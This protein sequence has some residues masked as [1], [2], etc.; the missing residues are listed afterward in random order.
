[1]DLAKGQTGSILES[2][3]PF[4]PRRDGA[5]W[6]GGE[7]KKSKSQIRAEQI[8]KHGFD[9]IRIFHVYDGQ[10]VTLCK[11]VHR[12]EN[13]AHKMAEDYCNGLYDSETWYE[14][15]ENSILKRLDKILNFKAQG[16]PV[17]VNGDPRGYALKIAD[18][19]TQAHKLEIHKDWG[20]YGIIAPEFD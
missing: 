3:K 2:S 8:L 17:F 20:G 7:M 15:K 11:K 9:L 12:L 19:Y 18:D 16:I 4:R 13:K 10:P 5:I 1:M 6:G 14:A